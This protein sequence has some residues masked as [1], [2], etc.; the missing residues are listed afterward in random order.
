MVN[1]SSSRD[2]EP[3]TLTA[4]T[5]LPPTYTLWLQGAHPS[6]GSTLSEV[7]SQRNLCWPDRLACLS[8]V[9]Q[10]LAYI[11]KSTESVTVS[12]CL[13]VSHQEGK[14]P[15]SRLQVLHQ[16]CPLS[17]GSCVTSGGHVQHYDPASSSS[18]DA[19][20]INSAC[21]IILPSRAGRE[22]PFPIC[23]RWISMDKLL[24]DMSNICTCSG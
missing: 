5:C 7:P 20:T 3:T 17:L 11:G 21:N 8:T 13:I 12:R 15:G 18:S 23:P 2:L 19:A 10:V 1:I 16:F 22:S 4:L 6:P 14:R 24:S 9:Q